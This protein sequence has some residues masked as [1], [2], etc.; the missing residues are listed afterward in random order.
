MM[1]F[2]NLRKMYIFKK[3]EIRNKNIFRKNEAESLNLV[4]VKTKL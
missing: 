4:L 1:Q 3:I 2:E